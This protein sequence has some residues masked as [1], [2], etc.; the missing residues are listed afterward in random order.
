MMLQ[1]FE[2]QLLVA[3]QQPGAINIP[4][5]PNWASLS[6]PQYSQGIFD[7]FIN[8]GYQR[9]AGDLRN[10][11]LMLTTANFPSIAE[12]GTYPINAPVQANVNTTPTG[13]ITAGLATVTPASI[14]NI[15]LATTLIIDPGTAVAEIFT[16]AANTATTFTAPFVFNHLSSAIIRGVVWPKSAVLR[17][18]YYSP[19]GLGYTQEYRPGGDLIS[20][21]DFQV[22]TDQGF[23]TSTSFA[24]QPGKMAVT[25]DRGNLAMFSGPSASGDVITVQYAPIP[26]SGADVC[27]FLVSETDVCLLPDD[28]CEAVVQWALVYIWL[29]ERQ[30]GM[31]TQAR[32]LYKEEIARAKENYALASAGDSMRFNDFG[33]GGFPGVLG[34]IGGLQGGP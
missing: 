6:N 7:F 25:P 26:T 18:A 10:Y 14:S 8:K 4:G 12:V 33:V 28:V 2:N 17:R 22:Y 20:W 32:A 9:V 30:A 21:E 11:N 31:A 1:D 27:P 29:R 5:A 24:T 3:V 19:Q 13:P 34:A 16:V 23:L 15:G